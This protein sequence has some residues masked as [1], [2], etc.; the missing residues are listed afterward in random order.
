ME[1]NLPLSPHAITRAHQLAE[2]IAAGYGDNSAIVIDGFSYTF[3]QEDRRNLNL[4]FG[5]IYP[6]TGIREYTLRKRRNRE[7]R[8]Q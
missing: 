1:I 7:G 4:L 3:T 6:V 2:M 5:T 8:K